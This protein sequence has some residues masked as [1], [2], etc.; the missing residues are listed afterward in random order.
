MPEL[1][2]QALKKELAEGTL[3]RL[4]VFCGAE[5]YTKDF[6]T[7]KLMQTAVTEGFESFNL[8]KLD[9][10]ECELPDVLEAAEQLPLMGGCNCCVVKDFPLSSLRAADAQVLCAY[11]PRIPDTTVLCFYLRDEAFPPKGAKDEGADQEKKKKQ[12]ELFEQFRQRAAIVRFDRMTDGAIAALLTRGAEKRGAKL[13]PACARQMIELC[14]RDLYLLLNELE[15]LCAAVGSG[16]ITAPLLQSVVTK[17]MEATSFEIVEHLLAGRT[18]RAL[19]SLRILLDQKTPAQM[20]LGAM[21]FPFVDMYRLKLAQNAGKGLRDVK[22]DFSYAS[23]FRLEKAQRSLRQL[24]LSQVRRCLTIL[25][26]ADT[27][28]KSRGGSDVLVLEETLV[29]LGAVL[30]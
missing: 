4:Y 26:E 30:C 3:R 13:S 25:N 2:E 9:G 1:S 17:T 12:K 7:Q 14:G 10:A 20:I 21:I 23:S 8:K 24:S 29:K 16:E 15:K 19:Q 5:G 27:A 11:L 18:D 6:Y 22:K 28:L